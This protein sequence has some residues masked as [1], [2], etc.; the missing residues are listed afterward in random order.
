[1]I[2]VNSLSYSIAG[3]AVLHNFNLK[4]ARGQHTL[5]LG[6]SG[7]GKTTLLH[8]LAGLLAPGAGEIAFDG[9]NI[10]ALSAD[11]KDRWR[12]AHIGMVFQTMHL[13]DALSI[14]D[15]LRLAAQMAG[16]AQDDARIAGLLAALGLTDKAS[17]YPHQLSVG[18]AQR[19]AIARA[20]VNKPGW[21]LADEPTSALDDEHAHA[22]IALLQQQ[23]EENNSTLIIA[24][25]DQR[26]KNHFAHTVTL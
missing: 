21:I 11:E 1:M 26:I 25:H 15:N 3:N 5:L 2:S 10:H 7:C 16:K 20:V 12:G 4:I 13:V 6:A 24:T 9:K 23:A 19:A 14:A 18:Q 8:L 22:T 17:R